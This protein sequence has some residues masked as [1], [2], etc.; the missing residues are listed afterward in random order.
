[1]ETD[2]FYAVSSE[3]LF[4]KSD[5]LIEANQ[6]AKREYEREAPIIAETIE[7]FK[8]Q[9]EAFESVYRVKEENDPEKF[10]REV[11]VNK[12]VAVILDAEIKRLE[13]IVKT[14]GKNTM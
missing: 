11:A 9:K 6:K 2:N 10:M 12:R 8:Q 14:Y 13:G 3:K 5:K 1:M 7:R 4:Q